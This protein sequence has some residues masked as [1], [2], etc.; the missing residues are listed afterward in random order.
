MKVR[1]QAHQH[2]IDAERIELSFSEQRTHTIPLE[3]EVEPRGEI[4]AR[5]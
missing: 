5:V 2:G 3:A 4:K 1:H